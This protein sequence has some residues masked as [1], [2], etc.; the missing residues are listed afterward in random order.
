M[1]K[2]IILTFVQILFLSTGFT[3]KACEIHL[4]VIENSQKD[5][6]APNDEIVIQVTVVLEHRNCHT[7]INETKFTTKGCK[8]MAATDWNETKPNTYQRKLK[9]KILP[10]DENIS[11]V[12]KR[13]CNKEGGQ[14][15]ITLPRGF[16]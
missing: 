10:D 1:R 12:C 8:I 4:K 16:E 9:I 6:Y 14:S 3:A 2:A 5:V 13:S 11:I 15:K 7:G